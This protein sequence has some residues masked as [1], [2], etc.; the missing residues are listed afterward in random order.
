MKIKAEIEK[1]LE[2]QRIIVGSRVRIT[3]RHPSFPVSSFLDTYRV[4]SVYPLIDVNITYY[5]I[6]GSFG[7]TM[8]V[9]QNEIELVTF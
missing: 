3:K 9:R 5:M 6:E 2:K 8:I 7:N 4:L 1:L